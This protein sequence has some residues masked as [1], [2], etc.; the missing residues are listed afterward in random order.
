MAGRLKSYIAM[1]YFY[2][3]FS[4]FF[5]T[6]VNREH[7]SIV[8]SYE[9]NSLAEPSLQGMS[10]IYLLP[11]YFSSFFSNVFFYFSIKFSSDMPVKL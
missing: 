2:N 8:N 5:E 3:K 4:F 7:I 9:K 6:K 1:S 10:I 11:L